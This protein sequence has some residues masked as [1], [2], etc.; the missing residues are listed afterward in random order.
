[1]KKTVL[2]IVSAGNGRIILLV[3][4][5]TVTVK[6]VIAVLHDK[7]IR[8]IGNF[9][10][11]AKLI[12]QSMSGN[13]FFPSPP[14]SVSNS[15]QYDNGI[16]ALD[17]AE[18]VALTRVKGSAAARDAAKTAVVNDMHLLQGYVQGIADANPTK[19]QQIVQSSGFDAKIGTPHSKNDFT[20]KNT[21]VSGTMKLMVNVK[22]ATGGNKRASFKWQM[23]TDEKEW[24]ELPSTL[25]GNTTVSGLTPGVIYFFHFLVI[26]KD[27]E[28]SWSSSVH[29]MAM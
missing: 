19:A 20:V 4:M 2:K 9:I 8:A 12:R 3:V 25:K 21:K 28:S 13:I 10:N 5:P 15:G 16:K 29:L 23:S 27:G 17:A 11:K 26:L 6:R 7:K 24:T 14:I 22:K 1:M 18:T